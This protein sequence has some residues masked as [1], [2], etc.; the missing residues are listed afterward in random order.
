MTISKTSRQDRAFT[1]IELLVVIAIIAIL[2]AILFPVFA[3]AREAAKST[4]CL[5]N[6]RQLGLGMFTYTAD[7][8]G[9]YAPPYCDRG[10]CAAWVLSGANPLSANSNPACAISDIY[11][12]D[13]CSVADPTRGSIYP[14][15]KNEQIFKCPTQQSGRYRFATGA[16]TPPTLNSGSQRVNYSMSRGFGGDLIALRSGG[17]GMTA[18]NESVI[19]FPSTTFM[20]V[21]EDVTSRNDGSFFFSTNGTNGDDFGRQHRNGANMVNADS[22]VKRISRAAL[23][24]GSAYWRR[25]TLERT[26]D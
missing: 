18:K 20:I 4:T 13:L 2:A 25:W 15:V 22:S 8:D 3:Q 14:Y 26:E 11:G 1:L 5:S 10:P 24:W 19:S 16:P 9:T 6:M 12:S 7:N 21:D 23:V 17:L